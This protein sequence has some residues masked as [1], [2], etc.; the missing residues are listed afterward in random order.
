MKRVIVDRY[1]GPGVVKIVDDDVSKSGPGEVR[2]RV[3]AAGVSSTESQLRA[4]TYIPGGPKAGP[5]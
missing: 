4:G 5:Q 3:L 1:G 2:V